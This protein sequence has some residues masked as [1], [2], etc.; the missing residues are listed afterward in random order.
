MHEQPIGRH[1]A[2]DNAPGAPRTAQFR[3]TIDGVVTG[4][5]ILLSLV[6][7]VVLLLEALLY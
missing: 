5:L 6:V 2:E 4:L 3:V 7:A 1:G